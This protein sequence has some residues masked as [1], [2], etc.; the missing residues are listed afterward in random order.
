MIKYFR[1][2]VTNWNDDASWSTTSGGANDTTKPTAGD[3]VFLDASSGDKVIIPER[4]GN[5]YG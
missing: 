4:R 5:Y 3:D 2:G 1:T